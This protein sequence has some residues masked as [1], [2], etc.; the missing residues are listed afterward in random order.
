MLMTDDERHQILQDLT[1]LG[2]WSRDDA[3][4]PT[5]D[6]EAADL[7]YARIEEILA[8]GASPVVNGHPGGGDSGARDVHVV[9]NET[10]YHL[11][12][13]STFQEAVCQAAL[14]LKAFLDQHPECAKSGQ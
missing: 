3:G 5:I 2:L 13:G 12:S 9:T 1:A 10:H 4:D 6:R 11:S 14:A 8:P 7:L